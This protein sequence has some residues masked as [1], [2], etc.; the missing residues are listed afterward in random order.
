VMEYFEIFLE[1]MI[2]CRTAANHLGCDFGL[3]INETRLQ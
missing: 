3:Y 1:R 2:M